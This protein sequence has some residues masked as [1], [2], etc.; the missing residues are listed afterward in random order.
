[1]QKL[2]S[3]FRM[4]LLQ[5]LVLLGDIYVT[6]RQLVYIVTGNEARFTAVALAYDRVGNVAL[7]GAWWQ[8]LSGRSGRKWPRAERFINWLFADPSHCD[9]ATLSDLAKL[10]EAMREAQA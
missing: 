4:L 10:Q 7:N 1:M 8:T 9:D 6:A 5:I 3:R 2:S